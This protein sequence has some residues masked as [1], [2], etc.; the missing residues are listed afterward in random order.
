MTHFDD[1]NARQL[2]KL[3]E[4]Y[5]DMAKRID[6]RLAQLDSAPPEQAEPKST[7]PRDRMNQTERRY[8][9]ILDARIR[10]GEIVEWWYEDL[11]F[12]VGLERTRYTPDFV[13]RLPSG[14]I[15]AHE[16][17]GARTW[18]DARVKFQAAAKQYPWVTWRMWVWE[19]GEWTERY[20]YRASAPVRAVEV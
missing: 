5:P 8:S 18:E 14:A 11:T 6:A 4:Q 16:I 13:V 17:K 3:R 20:H 9:L 12:R 2:K 15:E 19:K 10:A 1:L 7:D